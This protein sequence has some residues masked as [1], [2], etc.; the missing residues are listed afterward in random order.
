MNASG[1]TVSATTLEREKMNVFMPVKLEAFYC[2]TGGVGEITG[3]SGRV[4]RSL[5]KNVRPYYLG[6]SVQHS[7]YYN[8]TAATLY[9]YCY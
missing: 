4:A 6:I 1:H 9:Y 7:Y 2:L 5:R 8:V 3:D